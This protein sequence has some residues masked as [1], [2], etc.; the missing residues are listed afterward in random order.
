MRGRHVDHRE[1]LP[2][3]FGLAICIQ[4]VYKFAVGI[5]NKAMR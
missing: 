5:I 3:I 4:N 1:R 2:F